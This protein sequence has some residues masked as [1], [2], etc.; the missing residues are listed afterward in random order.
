VRE[1]QKLAQ[2]HRS[3][4]TAGAGRTVEAK[5]KVVYTPD[6]LL[7]LLEYIIKKKLKLSAQEPYF[8]L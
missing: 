6:S 2:H 5:N 7:F 8:F 4:C 3:S 1:G